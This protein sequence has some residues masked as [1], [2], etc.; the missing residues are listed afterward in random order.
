MVTSNRVEKAIRMLTRNPLLA[1]DRDSTGRTPLHQ[2]CRFG[3]KY[4]VEILMD[5]GAKIV[6]TNLDGK[7]PL[8]EAFAY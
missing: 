6:V 1:N 2:A 8:D 3:F 5:Y 4:I 7:T